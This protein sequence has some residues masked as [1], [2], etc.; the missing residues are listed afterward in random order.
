MGRTKKEAGKKERKEG[1]WAERKWIQTHNKPAMKL[2]YSPTHQ[3]QGV[4]P[5][6][7]N[8]TWLR[9]NAPAAVTSAFKIWKIFQNYGKYEIFR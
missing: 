6:L 9:R 7:Y 4:G 3:I 5:S 8:F 2:L 1:K